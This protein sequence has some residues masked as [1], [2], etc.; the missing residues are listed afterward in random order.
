M[1]EERELRERLPVH[2]HKQDQ[3]LRTYVLRVDGLVGQSLE[4]RMADLEQLE[5]R[6]LTEDFGC[7][8]GWTVPKVRWRGVPLQAVL[9]LAKVRP[10]ARYVQ[11]TAGDF[12]VPIPREKAE[13]A[14]L[15]TSLNEEVLVPE[16]GGPVR[17]VV[18][19]GECFTSIKWL[20]HLELREEA[21]PNTAE[22]IALGRLPAKSD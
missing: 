21:G 5:Q 9:S 20:D 2:S 4:L 6:D 7:L 22:K 8:E 18:P 16:H 19:G 13:G 3:D 14:L 17:L 10:E 12:S 1:R 11:A 15:A